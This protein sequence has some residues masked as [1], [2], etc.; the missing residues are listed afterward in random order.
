MLTIILAAGNNERFNGK[1]KATLKARDGKTVLENIVYNLD[2]DP[3]FIIAQK[4]HGRELHNVV[5]RLSM[6]GK[7]RTIFHAWI[8]K[9]TEGP[10]DTLWQARKW[11]HKI[12][13][14]TDNGDCPIVISY[15]DVLLERNLFNQFI[16][17]CNEKDAGLVIFESD[18]PRFQDAIPGHYK[19]S[20]IVFFRSGKEM[21]EILGKMPKGSNDG[22]P[23][24]VHAKGRNGILFVCNE[25]IDIG[26]PEDYEE[27]IND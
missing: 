15:C 8:K 19:N 24:M 5:D 7:P 9:S 22:I 11:I 26:T 12:L 20:G 23:D 18:N 21:M 25:V 13:D 14:S 6:I 10:L 4:K 1:H 17:A 27:Y 2:A 16:V 3:A